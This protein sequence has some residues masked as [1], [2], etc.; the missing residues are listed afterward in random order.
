MSGRLAILG[1][2][3]DFGLTCS[4]RCFLPSGVPSAEERDFSSMTYYSLFCSFRILC[5]LLA[6]LPSGILIWLLKFS[7]NFGCGAPI[8]FWFSIW[9]SKTSK[10]T[11]SFYAFI[12]FGFLTFAAAG[13]SSLPSDISSSFCLTLSSLG[14]F[15]V[16]PVKL[17]VCVSEPPMLI[18][19]KFRFGTA[20]FLFWCCLGAGS[21]SIF[22]TE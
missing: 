9:I 1:K 17:S 18:E 12:F 14:G 15:G 11:F 21:P 6:I 8:S 2:A 10:L 19:S 3:L 5:P 20:F 4:S 7:S 13:C 16:P 22:S